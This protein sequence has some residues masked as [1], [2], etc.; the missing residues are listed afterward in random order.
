MVA[1]HFIFDKLLRLFADSAGAVAAAV[2]CA[3][4]AAATVAA[5]KLIG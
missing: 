3:A 5:N 4:A 1:H 2:A